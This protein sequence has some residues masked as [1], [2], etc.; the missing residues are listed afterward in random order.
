[1]QKSVEAYLA[2]YRE[3]GREPE[4]PCSG[5][6][7]VQISPE[8]HRRLALEAARRQVSIDTYIQEILEQAVRAGST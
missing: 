7:A 3:Q 2:F 1:M 5:K 8:L 6:L 4:P